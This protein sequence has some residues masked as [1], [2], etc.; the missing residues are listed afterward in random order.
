MGQI[1]EMGMMK[2]NLSF[3]TWH[4]T[5]VV[6]TIIRTLLT[7]VL[8]CIFFL[9][10]FLFD[11]NSFDSILMVWILKYYWPIFSSSFILFAVSRPLFE[12]MHLVNERA[13]GKMF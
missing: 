10:F 5:S 12:K 4:K 13:L 2:L 11:E 6:K 9:S 7:I 8:F 1:F 3:L